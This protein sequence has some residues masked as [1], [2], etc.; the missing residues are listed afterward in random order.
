MRTK[1]LARS[2]R[3][4][5]APIKG[6]S[7]PYSR[8]TPHRTPRGTQSNAFSK[9]IKNTCRVVGEVPCSL[10][11]PAEGVELVHCSTARTKTTLLLL[12]PKFD[13]PADFPLQYLRIDLTREAEECDPPVGTRPLVPLFKGEGGGPP[14]RSAIPE[15]LS[16]MSTRCYKSNV[17]QDSPTTSRVLRNS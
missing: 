2:Y 6:S 1:L 3:D 14:P 8:S 7:T 10:Y 15:A 12:N 16:L 17:N 13:Y 5:T 9:S 4:R 11:D